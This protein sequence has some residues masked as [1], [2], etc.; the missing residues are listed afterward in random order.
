MQDPTK[1]PGWLIHRKQLQVSAVH[2]LVVLG[3]ENVRLTY[4]CSKV[5]GKRRE[6]IATA[7]CRLK[8]LF[9]SLVSRLV[10]VG[11]HKYVVYVIK[12]WALVLLAL[13]Y[14]K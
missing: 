7:L 2:Y 9:Y 8:I 10:L 5:V 13:E 1:L 11:I 4:R 12:V 6:S 14:R 3:V